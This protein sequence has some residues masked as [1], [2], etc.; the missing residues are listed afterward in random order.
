MRV[1]VSGVAAALTVLLIST[2]AAAQAPSAARVVRL[3]GTLPDAIETTAPVL[4]FAVYDA[5][6]GGRLLWEET[7]PVSLDG[8]GAYTVFL[9]AMSADG[10][11]LDLFAEGAPRWLQI[12]GAGGAPAPRILLAAVPYAVAAAT[13]ANAATL[14][15]RP[16]TDFQLTPAARRREASAGAKAAAAD[17]DGPTVNN[18]TANYIGKFVNN[19]DLVNSQLYDTGSDIGL[20]VTAPLEKF[21][22]RFTNG[23]GSQTGLAV[24]N[25]GSTTS[26]YSGMLFYDHTGALRQFQGYNNG[27][28]E[29]RINNISPTGSI[30]FMVGSDSKF[31]VVTNGYIGL[32]AGQ[33]TPS[34]RLHLFGSQGNDVTW[35]GTRFTGSIGSPTATINGTSIFRIEGEGHS[36]AGFTDYRSAIVSTA[37][38]TWTPTGNGTRLSFWTTPTGSTTTIER[39]TIAPNGYVGIGTNAPVVPLEVFG[40]TNYA[41]SASS[42]YFAPMSTS[43]VDQT[44]DYGAVSIRASNYILGAG[45]AA[46]SDARIKQVIGRSDAAADL[47]LID[48]IEVVDYTFRDTLAQGS[49]RQKKVVAQQVEQVYP[50]AVTKTTGVVPDIF[51]RAPQKDGWIMLATDLKPGERVRLMTAQGDDAVHEVLEVAPGRFRTSDTTATSQVFVYGREVRDFRAVDYEALAM[52]N[53]SA[54]QELHRRLEAQGRENAALKAQNATLESRLAALEA[55]LKALTTATPR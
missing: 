29:Y 32:G 35:R 12:S 48:R 36:G 38:E 10:L 46:V 51:T 16:A 53:V 42:R 19:V 13:A 50:Q 54:T 21:H 23:A 45:I 18:G 52:L 7:Q 2:P 17:I 30:N 4:R 3:T 27:T 15:G 41:N 25:M 24:Q 34:V 40:N 28:G 37:A 5:E 43:L 22:V 47:G 31:K 49:G 14:A 33:V 8:A 6:A 9:G 1:C 55:A 44:F 20:G 26:S 11:P 39:V